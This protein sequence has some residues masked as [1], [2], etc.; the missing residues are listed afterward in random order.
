MVSGPV[1]F[2]LGGGGVLGAVEV[3][4]LR[5]LFRADVRPDLVLGT[6]IG[7]VNGA[8]VAADP[9]EAVTDRLVRLWASPEASEVYGD[10]VARQLRRFAARTHL[11]SPRPLRRLLEAELGEETTFADLRVPFRCCAA[12]IERAAEHWFDAGPL[13]PAVLASASVPGLLPPTE[14]DGQHFIDGGIVNS[15]PIGAA[16]EAGAREVFV[17]QV[18]RIERELTPPRRPWEIA[19]VAF[20]IARRHRFS[21]EMA[22]LPDGVRVHVLP[23]GGPG[24][25]EDSPWAYRDMAAVGR[26]ISRAYTASRRYLATHLDR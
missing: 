19:Q 26:R 15:I 23:T 25:R 7:A 18:G 6:S 9:T 14:I 24:P 8:L 2:V 17:L 12:H 21:R 11:H 1:A 16:V 20:E 5:A 10:S 13:V 22:A 3:G 4:M